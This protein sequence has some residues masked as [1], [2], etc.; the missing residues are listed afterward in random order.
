MAVDD[1]SSLVEAEAILNYLTEEGCCREA[2]VILI[3]NKTDLVRN[4]IITA[5]GESFFLIA[6]NIAGF[7]IEQKTCVAAFPLILICHYVDIVS[8]KTLCTPKQRLP[9]ICV[10]KKIL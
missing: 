3:A 9:T 6:N 7:V 8:V 4:R 1:S 2:A 10:R 5:Q